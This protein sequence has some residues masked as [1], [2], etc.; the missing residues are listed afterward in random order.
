M[1]AKH[2][3]RWLVSQHRLEAAAAVLRT[4]GRGN[5]VSAPGKL[6]ITLRAPPPATSEGVAQLFSRPRLLPVTLILGYC[7]LELET[8][9]REP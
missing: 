8:N 5:G 2:C 6:D 7:W 4:I 3:F 9:L 1:L